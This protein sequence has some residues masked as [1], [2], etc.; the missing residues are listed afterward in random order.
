MISIVFCNVI[1]LVFI[2]VQKS[3]AEATGFDLV[4]LKHLQLE[5]EAEGYRMSFLLCCPPVAPDVAI[6]SQWDASHER[7][8]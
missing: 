4:W 3:T 8:R 5:L 7:Y 1:L 6:Y 2:D